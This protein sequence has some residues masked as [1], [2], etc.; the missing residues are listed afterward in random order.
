MTRVHDRFER[1]VVLAFA[2]LGCAWAT[3]T[4]GMFGFELSNRLTL[5]GLGLS[6]VDGEIACWLTAIAALIAYPFMLWGLMRTQFE[7]SLPRVFATSLLSMAVLSP[8]G[9]LGVP[10][11][12]V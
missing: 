11:S 8:A 9:P 2:T 10:P 4:V 12:L 6:G 5:V 3:A 7:R 1:A